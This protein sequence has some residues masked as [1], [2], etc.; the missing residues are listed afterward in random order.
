MI[1]EITGSIR[2]NW[3]RYFPETKIL[4][5]PHVSLGKGHAHLRIVEESGA[6]KNS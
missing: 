5:I 2:Y 6:I 4:N 1:L 3:K